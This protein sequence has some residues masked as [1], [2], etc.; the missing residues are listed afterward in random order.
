[1][2]VTHFNDVHL[3]HHVCVVCYVFLH[4]IVQSVETSI[5]MVSILRWAYVST[6]ISHL[7]LTVF[8]M[9]WKEMAPWHELVAF[10]YLSSFCIT[11]LLSL[12]MFR[13]YRC[14]RILV[15]FCCV[16][17]LL[18]AHRYRLERK[19]TNV[20]RLWWCAGEWI[21]YFGGCLVPV[22]F[23]VDN[24]SLQTS[25]S[26]IHRGH[27][28]CQTSSCACCTHSSHC[29]LAKNELLWTMKQ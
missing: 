13:T 10:T 27:P 25:H 6:I 2:F 5:T 1:M 23:V 7:C 8:T 17:F 3:L 26:N 24:S 18:T 20:H 16:V 28:V 12:Y 29:L 14:T 4:S 9:A 11:L 15:T 19:A 22:C 21:L